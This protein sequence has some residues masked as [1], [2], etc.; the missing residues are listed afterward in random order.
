MTDGKFEDALYY[1]NEI[2]DYAIIPQP[3]RLQIRQRIRS[4]KRLKQLHEGYPI[5][6]HIADL[7]RTNPPA[8]YDKLTHFFALY[9]EVGDPSNLFLQLVRPNEEVLTLLQQIEDPD[10]S[11]QERLKIGRR[12]SE[13][14]DPRLGVGLRPDGVPDIA[15][16]KI[17]EGDFIFGF[18]RH[19]ELPEYFISQY[20]IT[21]IQFQA[22]LDDGGLE[23]SIWWEDL[24]ERETEINEQL[25]QF[26]NYPRVR[27]S[28]YMAVAYCRWLSSKLGTEVRLPTEQ[29]WEKAAR[30]TKGAIYPWGTSYIAGYSN[31]NE[32]I[33]GISP[34]NL[35]EP[36]A[37][38]MYPHGQSP[39]GVH[40]MI[41]NV[42]EW[43]LNEFENP[44]AAPS[45]VNLYSDQK[46]PL[47]GGSWSSDRLFAHT[48]RR[49]GELPITQFN[50]IGFRVACS[51]LPKINF[52]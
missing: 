7:V 12:L 35:R 52:D 37:V 36:T 16:I 3:F 51:Y 28:W 41:G 14:D 48:V 5:Y 4:V 45:K 21:H 30:G 46:R 40:D 10:L 39:Y 22:F 23:E 6:Q 43:C 1:L 44:D 17:P 32:A 20:T 13:L 24:A 27:V 15:W 2:H 8:A 26:K 47:R 42:A 31:I 50:D 34:T 18:D 33:S 38:G 25:W 11:A 29:E 49:R 19:I 9:P